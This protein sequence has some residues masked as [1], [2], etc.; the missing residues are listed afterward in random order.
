MTLLSILIP[1]DATIPNITITP[2]PKTAIGIDDTIAPIL[3]TK[4][5]STRKTAAIVTTDLL[6]TPV[7]EINPTF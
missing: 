3:G 5:Q 7:I 2:P 1:A 6:I 4:P